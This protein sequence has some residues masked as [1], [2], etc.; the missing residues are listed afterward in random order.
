[1]NAE[2]WE[3]RLRHDITR[4]VDA[5]GPDAEGLG[6]VTDGRL[7][8]L[9]DVDDETGVTVLQTPIEPSAMAFLLWNVW[10]DARGLR[11]SAAMN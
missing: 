4:L 1:M 3:L 2:G 5:I 10:S 11:R 9:V 8:L 6:L 7:Y